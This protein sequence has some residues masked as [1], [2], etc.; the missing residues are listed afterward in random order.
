MANGTR[1]DGFI[2][3]MGDREV[4][5]DVDFAGDILAGSS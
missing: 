1:L 3:D 5:G 2:A 4:L